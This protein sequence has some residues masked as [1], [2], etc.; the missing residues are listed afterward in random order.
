VRELV[1]TRAL[2]TVETSL[3]QWLTMADYHWRWSMQ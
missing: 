3:R 1:E 2:K